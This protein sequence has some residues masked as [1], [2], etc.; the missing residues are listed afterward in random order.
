[1]KVVKQSQIHLLLA[2]LLRLPQLETFNWFIDSR[3]AQASLM[4]TKSHI[5]L[6]LT[7]FFLELIACSFYTKIWQTS[8]FSIDFNIV[9]LSLLLL[10]RK[11]KKSEGKGGEKL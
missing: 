6:L 8:L 9:M 4:S 11:G 2:S 3:E 5:L 7:Y 10:W 1:M